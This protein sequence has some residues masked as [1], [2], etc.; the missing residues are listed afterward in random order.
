MD[1]DADKIAAPSSS[2]KVLR[3]LETAVPDCHMDLTV[4]GRALLINSHGKA[5]E[6][7]VTDLLEQSLLDLA[8]QATQCSIEAGT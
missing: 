4:L 1:I 3:Y 7:E 8:H 2:E 5:N 6:E